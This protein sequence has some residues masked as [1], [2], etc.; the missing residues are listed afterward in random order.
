M[1]W[2][3]TGDSGLSRAQTQG[4]AFRN[5]WSTWW[6]MMTPS[7]ILIPTRASECLWAKHRVFLVSLFHTCP[8]GA[9]S[10]HHCTPA[11]CR[12][13]SL[14]H[15]KVPRAK[16]TCP[17]SCHSPTFPVRC[18]LKLMLHISTRA[19]FSRRWDSSGWWID[20]ESG[21]SDLHSATL[22]VWNW[23]LFNF[24]KPPLYHKGMQRWIK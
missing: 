16:K 10:S 21:S 22:A 15:G 24:S 6:V 5:S 12:V 17:S 3:K 20:L 19:S 11:L 13:C 9:S 14:I 8:R 1:Y 2:L 4:I 7:E 23:A 18:P